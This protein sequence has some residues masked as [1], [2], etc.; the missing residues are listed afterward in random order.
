MIRGRTFLLMN[1]FSTHRVCFCLRNSFSKTLRFWSACHI[2]MACVSKYRPDSHRPISP[3]EIALAFLDIGQRAKAIKLQLED[4]IVGVERFR[5]AGK[6]H[7]THVSGQ[8]RHLL[9][10]IAMTVLA[11]LTCLGSGRRIV[12]CILPTDA[13][14]NNS[15]KC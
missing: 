1:C 7:G 3:D 9:R 4:V 12:W 10:S 6:P 13:M 14:T 5:T 2:P 8:N 11:A 15:A